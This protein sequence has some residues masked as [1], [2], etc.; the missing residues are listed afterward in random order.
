MEQTTAPEFK[1]AQRPT[2]ITVLCIL[3]FVGIAISLIGGIMNYFTYSAL[4]ATGDMFGGLKTDAGQDLNNAMNAMASAIGMDYP[5]MAMSALVQ[6][7]FNIPIL[8]GVLMMWKQRKVGFWVYTV[9]EVIQAILPLVMGLGLIGG[10]TSVLML[11]FAILFIV[12]YGVNLKHM[13]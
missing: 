2:F 10:V 9:F 7:L 8:I 3:S 5:K 1:P 12:L 4:A 13:S 6:A 11:I